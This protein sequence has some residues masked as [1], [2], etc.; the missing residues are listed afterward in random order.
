MQRWVRKKDR[1]DA[2]LKEAEEKKKKKWQ[3]H[4]EELYK[5]RS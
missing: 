1:N 3:E 5:K 2:V 4:S